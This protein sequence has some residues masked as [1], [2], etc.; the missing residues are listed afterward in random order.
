MYNVHCTLPIV[1]N[2]TLLFWV[3]KWQISGMKYSSSNIYSE[4]NI[5]CSVYYELFNNPTRALGL[6][7]FVIKSD[8]RNGAWSLEKI[9]NWKQK[10]HKVKVHLSN[11]WKTHYHLNHIFIETLQLHC[12]RLHWS[13]CTKDEI[14][15]ILGALQTKC[16]LRFALYA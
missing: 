4:R 15:Q 10:T 3:W 8:I 16:K 13:R 2:R 1:C 6:K 9:R 12:Y 11:I 7:F 14:M 5:Q